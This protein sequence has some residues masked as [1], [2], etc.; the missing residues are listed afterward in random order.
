MNPNQTEVKEGMQE[1]IQNRRERRKHLNKKRVFSNSK[2]PLV[3][4]RIENSFLKVKKRVQLITD[5]NGKTKQ[6]THSVYC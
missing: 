5:K 6:I 3:V 1:P 2:N 4:L